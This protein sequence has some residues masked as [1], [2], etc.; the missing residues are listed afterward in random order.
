MILK[1]DKVCASF[2]QEVC[3]NSVCSIKSFKFFFYPS[4]I[5][6]I[7]NINF[8]SQYDSRF[9]IVLWLMSLYKE[10][11][12]NNFWQH[13]PDILAVIVYFREK[14]TYCSFAPWTADC[15]KVLQKKKHWDLQVCTRPQFLAISQNSSHVRTECIQQ[16]LVANIVTLPKGFVQ[17]ELYMDFQECVHVIFN[18][19][20]MNRPKFMLYC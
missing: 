11:L 6:F 20:K 4:Y 7:K 8:N 9:C 15:N 10:K 18:Q 3:K 12:I 5:C 2:W 16:D 1:E 19:I 17:F 13:T 14:H